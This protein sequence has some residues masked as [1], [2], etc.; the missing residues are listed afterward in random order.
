[1]RKQH[2]KETKF[3]AALEAIQGDLTT[4]QIISKYE[5]SEG[6][7]YKWKKQRNVLRNAIGR[8]ILIFKK[9]W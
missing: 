7:L 6:C 8:M 1:M 5:V 2:S 3:K 9:A 4:A